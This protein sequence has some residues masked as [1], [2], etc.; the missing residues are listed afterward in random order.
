[1]FGRVR[2]GSDGTDHE[3]GA[4]ATPRELR[5]DRSAKRPGTSPLSLTAAT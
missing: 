5:A 2:G 1:M 4:G 3:T